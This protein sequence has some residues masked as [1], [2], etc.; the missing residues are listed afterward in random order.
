M[1]REEFGGIV[2]DKGKQENECFEFGM[3]NSIESLQCET[4]RWIYCLI[5]DISELKVMCYFDF[6]FLS[7]HNQPFACLA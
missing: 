5:T 3:M 2:Q 1:K 4:L 6:F 7:K